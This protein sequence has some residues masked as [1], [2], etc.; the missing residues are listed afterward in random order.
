MKRLGLLDQ[1]EIYT[2]KECK[3]GLMLKSVIDS[4]DI[5][6]ILTALYDYDKWFEKG[7]EKELRKRIKTIIKVLEGDD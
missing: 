1:G 3:G 2:F 7:E 4:E 6:V 5:K